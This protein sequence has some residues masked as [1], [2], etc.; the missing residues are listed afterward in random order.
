M[1]SE[2]VTEQ[3]DNVSMWPVIENS[4]LIGLVAKNCQ[5]SWTWMATDQF[6]D[7]PHNLCRDYY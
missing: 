5:C 6:L 4:W 7:R 1:K 2:A 3:L